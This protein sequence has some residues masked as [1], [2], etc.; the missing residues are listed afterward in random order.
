MQRTFTSRTRRLEP[1]AAFALSFVSVIGTLAV[2]AVPLG[3]VATGGGS[4]AHPYFAHASIVPFA[5][6]TCSTTSLCTS[7]VLA[8]Y[9]FGPLL[10]NST[11]NGTGQSI[12]IV[13]ACG[14]SNIVTDV[15]T[16]DTAMGLPAINLS[17][18]Q[19]QG[20]PCSDPTGWG[21]ETAL[22][23]EWAHAMAPGAT[24]NL[25]EAASASTGS[26]Y[27][28]WNYTLVN[29]LGN[30]I[31]NSW[32]GNG[33]CPTVA[34]G[35]LATAAHQHVT[36]LASGG[37]SGRWGSGTHFAIQQPA[38]CQN[39][40]TIGGTSLHV[41]NVSGAYTSESA[42]SGGGGGYV[43]GAAEPAYQKTANI[44]DSFTVLG[45]PDVSAVADPGTGV[46]I[47]DKSAGGWFVVGGTSVSCPIWAGFVADVNSW[48]SANAFGALG[49]VNP[50]LYL[51]VYGANHGSANYSVTVHDV[52]T[53]S[54]G[55]SAGTGWDAATGIGSFKAYPLATLLA[56]S[57]KA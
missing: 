16:F 29:H 43:K 5:S 32:G 11:M 31:S 10:V 19:P 21:V 17:I 30:S 14:D 24:I 4:N 25:I 12:A 42:W 48:R 36:V 6:P 41:A 35:L 51:S 57:P 22:D 7:T 49:T 18:F 9:Q 38:D 46:W 28:A 56:N 3:A 50:F 37:D 27:G 20:T 47:F 33:A 45:K 52:T 55:W 34:R 53:G 8:A 40:L 13:D 23:V 26:L 39:V 54:N 15:A 1:Y 44:T 2:L